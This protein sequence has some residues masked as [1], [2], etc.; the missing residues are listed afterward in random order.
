MRVHNLP[1]ALSLAV[2]F[3]VRSILA[4]EP[5]ALIPL[6]AEVH[7]KTGHCPLGSD[8][9]AD[10]ACKEKAAQ[11][12]ELLRPA[13]GIAF[14]TVALDEKGTAKAVIILKEDA[15]LAAASKDAYR[16]SVTPERIT[17][18]GASPAGVF[19]GM[20][21]LRQLLPPQVFATSLQS[22]VEWKVPC[23]E[24]ADQPRFAWRG[25]MLDDSRH[26]LGAGY[27]KKT[28]DLMAIHKLNVLHWHLSDDDGFR[29]EIKSYP[30]LTEVGG[31][32]GTQ[33]KL[34]NTRPGENHARYGGF[35]TQDQIREIVAYAAARHVDIMP[36][37]DI[38]GH[39]GAAAAAYPEILCAG[40]RSGNVW[41][42]GARRITRC[43]TPW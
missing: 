9:A 31:W 5:A 20:Q 7:W 4:G 10:P 16:L 13:T 3:L 14:R 26:F 32:R 33:C 30:K 34:P 27:V 36:E 15:S 39:S 21:T 42:A 35:Y 17:I 41:C 28:I 6:P 22:G 23:V 37:I 24:I 43:S 8:I 19:Y 25:F 40:T 2:L 1:I 18:A 38:P 12:A 11:L 29:I